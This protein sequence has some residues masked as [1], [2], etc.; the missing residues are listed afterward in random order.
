MSACGTPGDEMSTGGEMST[1][2]FFRAGCAVSCG[3]VKS[4]RLFK[5]DD[6]YVRYL[7]SSGV[8]FS[9]SNVLLISKT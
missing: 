1:R 6:K 9:G 8:F 3:V 4:R 7:S 5:D 2:C